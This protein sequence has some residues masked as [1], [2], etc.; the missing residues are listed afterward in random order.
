[1]LS[2]SFQVVKLLSVLHTHRYS[3]C[4]IFVRQA[5]A[6][7][8]VYR[9]LSETHTHTHTHRC[10]DTLFR[11]CWPAAWKLNRR[12][13]Y[14]RKSVCVCVCVCVHMWRRETVVGKF[15]VLLLTT[16]S[17]WGGVQKLRPTPAIHLYLTSTTVSVQRQTTDGSIKVCSAEKHL[18]LPSHLHPQKWRWSSAMKVSG[19]LKMF[20]WV[21]RNILDVDCRLQS[22]CGA[23]TTIKQP[24]NCPQAGLKAHI[25]PALTV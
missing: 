6:V 10:K 14:K 23:Q 5:H 1:M 25:W 22:G 15:A 12:S 7:W 4:D 2:F 17:E 19:V 8:L 11:H 16:A 13:K 9:W 24:P 21:Q 3:A 18:G 20:L